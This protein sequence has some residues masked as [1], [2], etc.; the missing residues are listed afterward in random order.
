MVTTLFPCKTLTSFLAN[1]VNLHQNVFSGGDNSYSS[2]SPLNWFY[3]LTSSLIAK[4]IKIFDMPSFCT[5]M[6]PCFQFFEKY[7]LTEP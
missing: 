4:S 5:C 1:S 6:E 2:N 3:H 7:I